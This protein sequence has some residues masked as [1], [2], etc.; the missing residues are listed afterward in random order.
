MRST[1][2]F[3]NLLG[4]GFTKFIGASLNAGKAVIV[5]VTES[6]RDTLLLRL[7]AYGLDIDVAIEQG[8]YI[9]LD[10]AELPTKTIN[11]WLSAF[12]LWNQPYR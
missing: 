12:E 11:T 1:V 2:T 7:Q 10:A 6:H 3:K 4:S 5:I 9:P 8:R